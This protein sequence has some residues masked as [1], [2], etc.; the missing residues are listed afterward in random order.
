MFMLKLKDTFIKHIGTPRH[1]GRYPWGSGKDSYQ[2]SSNFL[3]YAEK[4]KY[5]GLS[6]VEIASG[7]GISVAEL[8]SRKSI[9]KAEKRASDSAMALRLKDKGLSNIAIG[10]R[11][12][13]NESSVRGLLDPALKTRADITVSTAN[14][15]RTEVKAK[16]YIDIGLGTETL[17]G[18]SRTKLNTAI[19]LLKD[20]GYEVMYVKTPQLGTGKYTS[21]KVLVAPGTDYYKDLY[22]NRDK[23]STVSRGSKDQGLTYDPAPPI[24]SIKSS[25][26]VI[27]YK[28]DGG[29]DKDGVIELRQGVNDI[30]L[31]QSRYAQVR[32]AVDKTHYLKG[33]AVYGEDMPKGVDVIYN[34]NKSKSVPKSSVLK[35]M[36]KDKDGNIDPEDPFGTVIKPNGRKGAL[37]IVNEEGDW[38]E[39]SATLSSQMLSKQSPGVAKKQLGLVVSKKEQEF[40]ELNSLTNPTVKKVLLNSFSDDADSSAS[41]L[42]AAALPRTGS[43]VIL[44]LTNIKPGE[45]YAPNYTQGERV[46]LIRHPHGGIFEIPELVVNNKSPEA[47]RLFKNAKDAVGIHPSVASKL[48][49]AD[50]DGD[51]VL[52]IPNKNRDIRTAPSLKALKDFSTT[53]MY[54]PYD[55]MRTIDG[56]KYNAVTKKVEYASKPQKKTKQLKMGDISNLITDM[57]IKGANDDE[58][59]RAVKHSMVVIDSEK[60][61]LNYKQSAIDNNIM[62]LKTKYQGG[63]RAGAST[64]VSKASSEKRVLARKERMPNKST[65]EKTYINTG[66][67]YKTT[68]GKVVFRTTS[69]TKM[70]YEKNAHKL[71]SGTRIESVYA[72]H[73]NSLKALANKA[74]LVMV[75]T[76]SLAYSPSANKV[77]AHEVATLKANLALAFMN[78]PRERQAQ[79]LGDK[80]FR[81]KCDANPDMDD[82]DKKKV[83]S[84]ALEE[85]RARTGAHKHVIPISDR[86]WEAI[87]MGAVSNHT[88]TTILLNTDLDKLKA[89]A[90]PR[91]SSVMSTASIV[92]AQAMLNAGK[93]QSEVA[94]ALGVS[95]NSLAKALD[96]KE[97]IS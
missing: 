79:L 55:G 83:K 28:E 6:E 35:E 87:Q 89:R 57:S 31:G 61:H 42:K 26:V 7:M 43:H 46:V 8:R 16:K 90:L 29:T 51:T 84:M 59:A 72:D 24:Q 1:S 34:T 47:N 58:L 91:S 3:G 56:G 78:K 38:K 5:E 73:A 96:Q 71:S 11:M 53:E 68:S 64:L 9:A 86:E 33:M 63:P 81:A 92:R 54:P 77:Y 17:M 40:N 85:A 52:V 65:G 94:A 80:I 60:H 2:R 23:I 4:L 12:G 41:H 95:T 39:W 25:R 22:L 70:E 21:I 18:I 36:K 93:T 50:F 76:P 74:R 67:T 97:V 30:S 88:L 19:Q 44:P 69:I 20:E 48:S 75:N 45:I 37:N 32:I 62:A 14:V 10:K 49:G 13:L 27:R 66:E 15:L 82:G